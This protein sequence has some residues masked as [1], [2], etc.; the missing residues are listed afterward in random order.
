MTSNQ[1]V[2]QASNSYGSHLTCIC[3]AMA[4]P[5]GSNP[6]KFGDRSVGRDRACGARA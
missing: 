4:T 2:W 6:E 3:V 5:F 1:F